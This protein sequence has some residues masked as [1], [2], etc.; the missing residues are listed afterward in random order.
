MRFYLALQCVVRLLLVRALL[1]SL[2]A[3]RTARWLALEAH[4]VADVANM[5][6]LNIWI[7]RANGIRR[8]ANFVP[9]TQC[10]ARAITLVWW[11]RRSGV[12]A[13]LFVGVK[14]SLDGAIE[15]HAWSSLYDVVLDEQAEIA[16]SFTCIPF[17]GSSPRVPC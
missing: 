15:A 13:Q 4:V 5:Q 3:H 14:R 2:G 12:P 10:L 11:A 8:V 9:N 6:A 16:A 17:P 1:A 7:A